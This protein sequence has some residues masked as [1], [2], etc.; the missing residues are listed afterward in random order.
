M[1]ANWHVIIARDHH[2]VPLTA[3]RADNLACVAAVW[4]PTLRDKRCLGSMLLAQWNTRDPFSWH[5]IR[6]LGVRILG[7]FPPHQITLEHLVSFRAMLA[8]FIDP[9]PPAPCN[10][11]D[12]IIINLLGLPNVTASTLWAARGT[13][14]VR[15]AM[16][17]RP[18]LLTMPYSAVIAVLPQ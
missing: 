14:G 7:G 8:S 1:P 5:D 15:L 11:G 13:V 12:K 2:R 3:Q 16:L 18:Q 17:G 10:P 6:D 4:V 9:D